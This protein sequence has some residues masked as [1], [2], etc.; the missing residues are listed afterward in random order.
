MPAG[1]RRRLFGVLPLFPT[2]RLVA[3]PGEGMPAV[4]AARA[5]EPGEVLALYEGQEA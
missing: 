5:I 2:P 4:E 1:W 3:R